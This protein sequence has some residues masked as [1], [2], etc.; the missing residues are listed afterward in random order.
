M[1]KILT[2]LAFIVLVTGIGALIGIMNIPGEWY[3]SLAKPSFN[4][5]NWIFGPVWTTLYVLIG[6]AGARTWLAEGFSVRIKIWLA[7]MML[8]FLWSPAFFGLHST[9][10]GLVVILPMLAAIILFIATSWRAD[11][12]S[13]LLFLPYL[14]WVGFATLLNAS[15]FMLN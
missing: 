15:L 5:P 11:R 12:V 8:N 6:I 4:P 3:Q 2:Y 14:A 10:L 13:A 7:Q 1:K 9:G